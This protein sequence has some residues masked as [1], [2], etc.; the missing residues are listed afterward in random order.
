MLFRLIATAIIVLS[1]SI[2]A[3]ALNITKPADEALT[4]AAARMKV[5]D[6]QGARQ[7]ALKSNDQGA[8][9]F[10]LGMSSVHLELWEEAVKEM[11][12][13][14]EY[15]PILADYALYYQGL[16]LT[17]L[18]RPDD[19]LVPLYKMLKNY[20]ESRLTRTAMALY[21]DTMAEAGHDKEALESYTAFIDRYPSGSDSIS[22]LYNVALCR[23]R[24]GDQAGAAAAFRKMWLKY[25]ASSFADKAEKELQRLR[26][27]GAE[28]EPYSKSELYNRAVTLYDMKKYKQAA[29]DFAELTTAGESE[30][31][32]TRLQLK[33]GQA[34]LK[35]KQ[36]Q[37][38]QATFSRLIQ[39]DA[40]N[41]EARFWLAK[42]MEKLGKDDEAFDL[43]IRLSECKAGIADDA[44]LEAAYIKRWQRKWDQAADLFGKY[45]AGQPEARRSS[46]VLWE[47]AWSGYQSR[48]YERAAAD[49]KKLSQRDDMR[50]KALY[51]LGRSLALKGDEKGSEEAFASLASEFPF[52]FYTLIS[53]RWCN[54]ADAPLAPK[55]LWEAV[56]IPSGFEREKALI[57]LGLYDEAG[58]EL[59][60]TRKKNPVGAARLYLEM[61]NFNGAYHSVASDRNKKGE[62]GTLWGLR[63]PQAF[64]DEVVK[65]AALNGLSQNLVWAIIRTESNYHPTALS[66]VGAVGLMQI[67]PATAESISK[68]DGSRLT[69]P[70][71]N[72]RLGARHIKDLMLSYDNNLTLVIAAYNAGSGNVKR[73]Q[74]GLGGLPKD[75][76]IESIPFKETREYVKKVM[77]AMEL[78]QRLYRP[79]AE[80]KLEIAADAGAPV[81]EAAG[82]A[83]PV[84][85]AAGAGEPAK[86]QAG[87]GEPAKQGAEAGEP[88][89]Q[90]AEAG[91]TGK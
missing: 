67:M 5:K 70:E 33:I 68:G 86:Q 48:N 55:N 82:V 14:E 45:L 31:F 51:W 72:I 22:A 47:S 84:I 69:T 78:Y 26:V 38:A 63:Y 40:G 17:K 77:T 54:S 2:P 15:Y 39:K 43:L 65:N 8:R 29:Q 21:A 50:D 35:G 23:D 83:E 49:F 24:L 80:Q 62:S 89:K 44:L 41:G 20:P 85:Q 76:F 16:A 46:A 52:G 61:E 18:K 10:L 37:E 3:S 12:T 53:D 19:A 1:A 6:Y 30:E 66:P 58:R 7:A 57:A 9:F 79:P 32:V 11:A 60:L 90:G 4:A 28:V 59:L 42:T 25:P 74:K 73:W 87:A 88:A 91:A 34:Q 64:R 71:L 56:P 13:A 75:E 27:A 81:K 36:Y